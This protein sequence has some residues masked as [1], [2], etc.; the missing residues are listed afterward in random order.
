MAKPDTP[1]S[2]CGKLLYSGRNSRPA[3][4][5]VCLPCRRVA[6]V[7]KPGGQ[8]NGA[9]QS[10]Q[11]RGCGE[12]FTWI[13]SGGQKRLY[14]SD[15]CRSVPR[16]PCLDCGT[17]II[18]LR[19]RCDPCVEEKSRQK[20]RRRRA[21]KRG[22]IA[23]P[24]TLAEIAQRDRHRCQLCRRKVDLTVQWPDPK[25]PSIDH[26]IPVSEGGGDLK[27]NV[28]LAHFGCNSSKG[29]R[30]SQQLALVG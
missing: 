18:L 12:T 28:Q 17:P 30:G 20:V 15:A 22:G 29:A 16:K 6:P 25:S 7:H 21:L 8:G 19:K 2:R 11:C 10:L 27:A 13:K 14:C 9:S 26:V 1:C 23:E 24:Y 4:L 5:R 3:D